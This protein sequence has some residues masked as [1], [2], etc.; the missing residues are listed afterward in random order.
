M[1]VGAR[2][3]VP[4][5]THVES[6]MS[7]TAGQ[8]DVGQSRSGALTIDALG[9]SMSATDGDG[10]PDGCLSAAD[11]STGAFLELFAGAGG[12]TCYA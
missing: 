10:L 7:W 2:E 1:V 4:R 5:M 8:A 6:S 9:S 3:V 12:L 11:G